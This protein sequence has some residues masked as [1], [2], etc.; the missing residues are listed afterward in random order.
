MNSDPAC[1]RVAGAVRE[2]HEQS[3]DGQRERVERELKVE[4]VPAA[5]SL[6]GAE[7]PDARGL[8]S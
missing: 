7:R 3:D 1:E 8:E 6:A 2:R 5:L 4:A